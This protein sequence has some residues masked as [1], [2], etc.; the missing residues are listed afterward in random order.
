MSP[1][2]TPG[3]GT[4][5]VGD[6]VRDGD[7]DASVAAPVLEGDEVAG[8]VVLGVG[9]RTVGADVLGAVRTAA[10]A[11]V[12]R[13]GGGTDR[14]PPRRSGRGRRIASGSG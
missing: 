2:A 5:R 12:S 13:R 9:G 7:D 14:S 1:K 6:R 10:R 3:L 4:E 11:K 8:A